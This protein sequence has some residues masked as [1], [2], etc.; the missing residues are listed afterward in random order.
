LPELVSNKVNKQSNDTA[1][2]GDFIKAPPS[3]ISI[4]WAGTTETGQLEFNQ[5]ILFT[6]RGEALL[7]NGDKDKLPSPVPYVTLGLGKT[8]DGSVMKADKDMAAIL[9]GG[10]SGRVSV[11]RP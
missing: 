7:E 10:F 3:P 8:I 9:V 2:F 6:P 5:L 11:V 4:R 1:M